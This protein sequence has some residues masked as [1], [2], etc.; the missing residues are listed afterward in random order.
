[1]VGDVML[2]RQVNELLREVPAEYPWG[3]T[4]SVLRANDWRLCNLECAISDGGTPWVRTEK[5]FHFRSDAKN[6]AVLQAA[7]IDMVSVANNHILDF[8]V[9]AMLDT[10]EILDRAG[11]G[12]AGA[13]SNFEAA[14][15]PAISNVRSARI[16]LLSFTDNQPEWDA[17]PNRQGVFY[18]PID[19]SDE[20]AKVLFEAVRLAAHQTDLL[21]VSPH[22]GPNWGCEPP[23][24]HLKF[25]HRLVDSGADI[26]FGHSG[27]VFRGIEF[28]RGRP[29]I[30]CAGNFI[31]DYAV[32]ETEHNDESFIFRFLL[33]GG[34][35]FRLLLFP[36]VILD[37]QARR[38]PE[39]RASEIAAKMSSLCEAFGTRTKWNKT[40]RTLE[41]FAS[42]SDAAR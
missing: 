35:I 4:L 21:I 38:A 6:I 33:Q 16:G 14:A 39:T 1:M 20:R 23:P 41:V 15:V 12:H 9:E 24:G 30:Y 32:D 7:S 40:M 27:H 29:I 2:G 18:V 8:E 22:W 25:A 31:D 13:G 34:K 5:A 26:V 3:D 11:I 36:T 17:G 10:L 19:V 37:C 42:K 28:Y